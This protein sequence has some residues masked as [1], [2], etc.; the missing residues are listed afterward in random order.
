[1]FKLTAKTLIGYDEQG[2]E[3]W[4]TIT[5][6]F[7]Y[8]HALSGNSSFAPTTQFSNKVLDGTC[9]SLDCSQ[10]QVLCDSLPD[11]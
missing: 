7:A 3:K 10:V 9:V 2:Q 1:M 5:K 11:C 4:R 6:I 8:N